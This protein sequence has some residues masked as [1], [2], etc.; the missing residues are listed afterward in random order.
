MNKFFKEN[1]LVDQ[2][3]V[4]DDTKSVAKFI[5]DE[6]QKAGGQAKIKRF[7]RFEIG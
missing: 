6:G 1:C 2:I 5:A 3:F 4:K 7:V